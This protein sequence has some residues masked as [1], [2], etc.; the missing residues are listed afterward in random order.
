[1]NV[2]TIDCLFITTPFEALINDC[3]SSAH[4]YKEKLPRIFEVYEEAVQANKIRCYGITAVQSLR[5]HPRIRQSISRDGSTTEDQMIQQLGE[6]MRAAEKVGGKA[7]HYRFVQTPYN[8]AQNEIATQEDQIYNNDTKLSSV[9]EM[10]RRQNL[11]LLA[12]DSVHLSKLRFKLEGSEEKT[13][14]R[15]SAVTHPNHLIRF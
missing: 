1:L 12:T 6:V 14:R 4:Y 8:S 9:L 10:L 13:L 3:A 5:M 11:N 2:K 7:H 15:L